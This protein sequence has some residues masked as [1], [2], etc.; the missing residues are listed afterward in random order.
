M[1]SRVRRCV[2]RHCAH[3]VRGD[4]W[5]LDSRERFRPRLP[6]C[7][8]RVQEHHFFKSDR[9]LNISTADNSPIKHVRILPD[10]NSIG[11]SYNRRSGSGPADRM[12]HPLD[13]VVLRRP[14]T[15]Y[16]HRDCRSESLIDI[17][18]S[19][20]ANSPAHIVGSAIQGAFPDPLALSADMF[21]TMPTGSRSF[22]RLT[23]NLPDLA[24]ESMKFPGSACR[25]W[26]T[27]VF[28]LP[29]QNY[30]K[31]TGGSIQKQADLLVGKKEGLRCLPTLSHCLGARCCAP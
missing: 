19:S 11:A 29:L 12:H 3:S 21:S 26:Q 2:A 28:F 13:S 27:V 16:R 7:F 14:R 17:W 10:R 4:A 15:T 23:L 6:V 8:G 24:F 1:S 22:R 31:S 18:C 5:E 25:C 20:T 9:I 30:G